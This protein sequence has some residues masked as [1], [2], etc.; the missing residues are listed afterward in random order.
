MT[1]TLVQ[2]PWGGEV[3]WA[4]LTLKNV[5][6]DSTIQNIVLA[7]IYS[8]PKSKKKTALLDHVAEKYNFLSTKYGKG[9]YWMLAGRPPKVDLV[10]GSRI[11]Q[12]KCACQNA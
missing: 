7:S 4:L 12:G 9:L 3:T 11:L 1:N 8:K 10:P 5:S 6:N 2:I